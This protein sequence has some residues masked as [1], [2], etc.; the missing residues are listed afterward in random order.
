MGC[1]PVIRHISLEALLISRGVPAGLCAALAR[2]SCL[3]CSS[4]SCFA[5][6]S[7]SET[8]WRILTA[9]PVTSDFRLRSPV[10]SGP[11]AL[12]RKAGGSGVPDPLNGRSTHLLS[13]SIFSFPHKSGLRQRPGIL[14]RRDMGNGQL[15]G[16]CT[17]CTRRL[18]ACP[19]FLGLLSGGVEG[20]GTQFGSRSR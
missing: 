14:L 6:P 9:L 18:R 19:F 16:Q 20:G 12:F 5:V 8:G 4:W 15:G 10:L 7:F 13:A 17:R 1:V 2:R 3:A 11:V